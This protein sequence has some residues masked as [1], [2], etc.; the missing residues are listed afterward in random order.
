MEHVSKFLFCLFPLFFLIEKTLGQILTE[1]QLDKKKV[2][3]LLEEAIKTPEEVYILSIRNTGQWKSFPKEIFQFKKLQRLSITG[4]DCDNN[5]IGCK[6]L[7]DI[8]DEIINLENLQE[9]NLVMNDIKEIPLVISK[10]KNLKSLDLSDNP[11]LKLDNL[12]ILQNI[13]QL[14][15]NGCGIQKLP[16]DVCLLKRLK[17]LGLSNNRLMKSEKKRIIKSLPLCEIYF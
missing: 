6:N 10:M 14:G 2:F 5:E 4:L 13:E 11:G 15:L 9:L 3:L 17:K 12:T 16:K 7:Q 8:P 1:E